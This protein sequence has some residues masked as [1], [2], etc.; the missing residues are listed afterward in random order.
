MPGEG[1]TDGPSEIKKHGEVTT[2][3]A[4]SSGIPCAEVLTLM[5]CSPWGPGFLAPIVSAIISR[6]LA[7]ASGGQDHTLS[8]PRRQ[9]SSRI[10]ARVHRIPAARFVTIGRNAPLH[11]GG[12]AV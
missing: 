12:M 6:D 11:R 4:E 10:A 2:G 7:S 5:A 1:V 9:C 8:R 3:S